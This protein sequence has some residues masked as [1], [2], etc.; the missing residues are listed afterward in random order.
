LVAAYYATGKLGL[1][2][3][4]AH[5]NV[6]L[7]WLPAGIVLAALM[8]WGWRCIPGIMLGALLTN[9][10]SSNSPVFALAAMMGST[11]SAIAGAWLLWK[12]I[13]FHREMDRVMDMLGLVGLASA[14]ATMLAATLGVAGFCAAGFMPWHAYRELWW[15][16]WVGDAMG[17]LMVAPLLFTLRI[18]KVRGV[19][20]RPVIQLVAILLGGLVFSTL[21]FIEGNLMESRLAMLLALPFMVLAAFRFGP[22]GVAMVN[23]VVAAAAA[24][25]IARS[26][27]R[28]DPRWMDEPMT[29]LWFFMVVCGITAQV[30]AS[31][32]RQRQRSEELFRSLVETSPDGITIMDMEGCLTFASPRTAAMF[33][34]GSPGN[35]LGRNILDLFATDSREQG[36][37]LQQ[38]LRRGQPV[39]ATERSAARADGACFWA[40]SS[41]QVLRDADG[42]PS[43]MFLITRNITDR[44]RLEQEWHQ[45]QKMEAIGRLAGGVA[46][47]FNNLLMVIGGQARLLLRNLTAQDP[48]WKRAE[49][50]RQA[51]NRAAGI[52]RQLL[53]LG[54]K[55]RVQVVPVSLGSLLAEISSLLHNVV[56]EKV[57]LALVPPLRTVVIEADPMQLQQVLI[58]LVANARDAVSE[59]G[60]ISVETET[61]SV[62]EADPLHG[63]LPA[64]DYVAIHIRD[65]GHGMGA[66]VKA[67]LFEPFFTT[68]K[69][70]KGTGLGLSTAYGIIRQ[71]GGHISVQSET[72]KGATFSVVLPLSK[73]APL[74]LRPE[75][76]APPLPASK[77]GEGKT[78]LLVEDDLNVRPVIREMLEYHAFRVV[79]AGNGQEA[80]DLLRSS[81]ERV[82]LVL[83]DVVM[84]G[85]NGDQLA[86]IV[87][88]TWPDLRVILMSGYASD[89]IRSGDLIRKGHL[90]LAKPLDEEA[91]LSQIRAILS[92]R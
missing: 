25:Q 10:I 79:E 23:F 16:W 86:E 8:A 15:R 52:T 54:R 71:F 18:T 63:K 36:I 53:T 90:L 69:D 50:I 87:G 29:I 80:L 43:A 88:Q 70:G 62:A 64:G 17:V 61:L 89:V 3:A 45:A 24:T 1:F 68:K 51:A 9:F 57:R 91:L 22:S 31:A 73:E 27:P 84:P 32:L 2:F 38:Q 49:A 26:T 59:G 58:N 30:I 7:I 6:T 76:G 81:S 82:A 48:G 12:A 14:L 67:H 42:K 40:E 41:G 21:A 13:G 75:G 56:G 33:G 39:N 65:N 92:S 47:D 74:P 19:R 85:M 72:E 34:Y 20:W 44:K 46:H 60:S 11:L 4:T 66:E 37:L 78:I 77:I 35:M 83:S 55:Q 28:L 5:G